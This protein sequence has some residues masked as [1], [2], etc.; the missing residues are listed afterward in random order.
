MTFASQVLLLPLVLAA[1]AGPPAARRWPPAPDAPRL[2]WVGE[3]TGVAPQAEAGKVGR[4]VRFLLGVVSGAPRGKRRLVRPTGIFAGDGKVFVADPGAG[5][6]WRFD[7]RTRKGEWLPRGRGLRLPSPVSVAVSTQGRVYVAD[8]VLGR[9]F[10]LDADGRSFGELRGDPQG[11][12]RPAALALAGDRLFVGDV[13]GHRVSAYGLDGG[14]LYS[15]GRRGAGRGELNYPTYL[16]WD[17][18]AKRLWVCDSGNFRL[19][20]FAFDGSPTASFGENGDRPGYLARPRGLAVDSDGDVYSIDGALEALQVFDRS[21]RLLLYVGQSGEGAGEF[22]LPGGA[23]ID[24]ADRLFVADTH[25]AR[26]Q[27][28]RYLKEAQP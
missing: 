28:F 10:I 4:I 23:F 8:S 25:N 19:Q 26:V 9:V 17:A 21:G 1:A 27:I 6:V 3:L 5:G 2:E 22:S 12:G 16:S 13:H 11:M 18:A 24:A 7:E 20:S 15:F 14:Y